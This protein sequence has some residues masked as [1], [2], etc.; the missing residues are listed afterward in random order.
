MNV[1]INAAYGYWYPEGQKRLVES[2]RG[3]TDWKI[4]TWSEETINAFF[5]PECP[6]T[7]KAAAWAEAL[8]LGAKKILWLDCSVWAIKDIVEIEDIITNEGGYFWSSGFNLAQTANDFSLKWAGLN[9]DQAEQ[10]SELASSMFGVN[11]E[12]ERGKKFSD[13]FLQMA[14]DKVFHGSR[15]HDHQSEDK[16][17]LFHRQDQTAASI[18]FHKSGFKKMYAPEVYS[19]YNDPNNK[20]EFNKSV[21]LIMQGM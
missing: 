19:S 5:D 16:R 8:R 12:D 9:R 17:F 14:T 2:L 4:I 15:Q 18:A 13:L 20:K 11:L 6:Y 1:I 21:C 10:M 3:K 7:I